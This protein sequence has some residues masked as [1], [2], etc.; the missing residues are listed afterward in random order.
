MR[1]D[2]KNE[3]TELNG[4]LKRAESYLDCETIILC[5]I[6]KHIVK[7]INIPAID[8]YMKNQEL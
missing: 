3:L 4:E 6:K 2:F 1:A 7:G 5:Y 8:S